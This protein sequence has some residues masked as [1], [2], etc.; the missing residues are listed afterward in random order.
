MFCSKIIVNQQ[1][2]NIQ[3]IYQNI[4][5]VIQIVWKIK[6]QGFSKQK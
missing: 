1:S 5:E 3:L 4:E 6:Q 2:I